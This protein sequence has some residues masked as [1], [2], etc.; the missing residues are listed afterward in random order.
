MN[1]KEHQR[2]IRKLEIGR[3]DGQEVFGFDWKISNWTGTSLICD[4][5]KK[6]IVCSGT[7]ENGRCDNQEHFLIG[8]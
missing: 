7:S 3:C 8:Q 2:F 4:L 1:V 5:R 6:N